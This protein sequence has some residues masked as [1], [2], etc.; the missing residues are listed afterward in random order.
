MSN[1]SLNITIFLIGFMGVGKSHYGRLLA[2]SLNL[3]FLDTDC[4]I[5]ENEKSSILDIFQQ[6]GESYF[7]NLE[8]NLIQS[9]LP[10]APCVVACGGG[11]PLQEGN[12]GLLKSKGVV[13]ALFASDKTIL[14][15]TN[16]N[17]KRPL[18]NVPNPMEVISGMLTERVP[19]YLEAD[20]C[21]STDDR[22]P[23]DVVKAIL[24][25][26]S[27]YCKKLNEAN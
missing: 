17:K 2:K 18:L 8:N 25:A 14:E 27:E 11:L 6:K 21:I 26:Y 10:N 12:M 23:S 5:E 16:R 13:I 7:R 1:N 3:K 22:S 15:R 20:I 19:K 4:V 24:R 9:G